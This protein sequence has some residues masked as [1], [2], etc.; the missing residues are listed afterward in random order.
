MSRLKV[1]VLSCNII[2]RRDWRVLSWVIYYA[3]LLYPTPGP[4]TVVAA[5]ISS[6][7][8]RAMPGLVD[9]FAPPKRPHLRCGGR[10][11]SGAGGRSNWRHSGRVDTKSILF[12]RVDIQQPY[13]PL[14]VGLIEKNY[15]QICG[16]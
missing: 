9:D 16:L 12:S 13:L 2:V 6:A 10:S 11:C 15:A 3:C 14:V 7:T 8:A 4:L 1:I 5:T